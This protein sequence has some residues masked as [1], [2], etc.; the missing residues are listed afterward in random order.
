VT[1]PRAVTPSNLQPRQADA[2]VDEVGTG[3]GASA[4]G[5][6]VERNL[7][8][9]GD[10][11]GGAV[12][13]SNAGR[14]GRAS[15]LEQRV[16]VAVVGDPTRY[17]SA[18][19]KPPSPARRIVPES[20]IRR[21]SQGTTASPRVASPVRAQI[22][23]PM[24]IRRAS[25]WEPLQASQLAPTRPAS[26]ALPEPSL[27]TTMPSPRWS[28]LP[29]SREHEMPLIA[30]PTEAEVLAQEVA[31]GEV[32]LRVLRA[33]VEAKEHEAIKLR[34]QVRD[35][36]F[37]LFE[38]SG[39]VGTLS[40]KVE[41]KAGNQ[42]AVLEASARQIDSQVVSLRRKLAQ[43][44]WE[45]AEKDEE[46]AKLQQ[47][48]RDTHAIIGQQ[49]QE[50]GIMQQ[51]HHE[52][53]CQ[54]MQLAMDANRLQRERAMSEWKERVQAQ[55]E[56]DSANAALVRDRRAHADQLR[57]LD[58]ENATCRAFICRM[59]DKC[60]RQ[61]TELERQRRRYDALQMEERL[62]ASAA[63]LG[64]ETADEYKQS[65]LAEHKALEARIHQEINRKTAREPFAQTYDAHEANALSYERELMALTECMREISRALHV[66]PGGPDDAI[67][68]A[69]GAFLQSA[70]DLG[71]PLPPVVRIGPSDYLVGQ[72]LLQCALLDGRLN[73]RLQ[74]GLL[75]G[76]GDFMRIWRGNNSDLTSRPTFAGR[77]SARGRSRVS[78][79][80][81]RSMSPTSAVAAPMLQGHPAALASAVVAPAVAAQASRGRSLTPPS[82][83]TGRGSVPLGGATPVT[84]RSWGMPAL[85]A[86]ISIGGAEQLLAV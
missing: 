53:G 10:N 59:E 51:N 40:A 77:G 25:S 2:A 84:S 71:E 57:N 20:E 56:E 9:T 55:V 61:V 28:T 60:K 27:A 35:V 11:G 39:A 26:P 76:I 19:L 42:H 69:M 37:N 72:D 73:V 30:T 48:V 47:G 83:R 64:H 52:Q 58:E 50:L 8:G 4:R 49:H 62:C 70:R 79:I 6:S 29:S 34:D 46:I 18:P 45:L 24:T 32:E 3:R 74:G 36:D 12:A 14:G 78:S 7:C 63:R 75:M 23:N 31:A 21:A 67:D 17:T 54:V 13:S 85:V 15:L 81:R 82:F 1:A 33:E 22:A 86:P 66:G 43:M 65:Q 44:E 68:A 38:A 80:G 41:T 16:P 5:S